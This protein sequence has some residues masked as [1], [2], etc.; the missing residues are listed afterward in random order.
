MDVCLCERKTNTSA[1]VYWCFGYPARS[2]RDHEVK[3][4]DDPGEQKLTFRLSSLMIHY[5]PTEFT[6]FVFICLFVFI[7]KHQW[8]ICAYTFICLIRW[9][10]LCSWESG[11]QLVFKLQAGFVLITGISMYFEWL[12]HSRVKTCQ[13]NKCVLNITLELCGFGH[14]KC[15]TL[16]AGT[17]LDRLC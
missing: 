13:H 9:R 6:D 16:A 17:L 11:L 15:K 3:G 7:S 8:M 2:K 1:G 12:D 14:Y 4:L 5:K 10:L